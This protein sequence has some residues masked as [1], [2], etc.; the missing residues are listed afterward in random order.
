MYCTFSDNV[1][2]NIERDVRPAK[3]HQV[4]PLTK[5]VGRDGP[6]SQIPIH[7]R[8]HSIHPQIQRNPTLKPHFHGRRSRGAGPPPE[9]G[10]GATLM[11][12][13]PSD[14]VI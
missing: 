2:K 8:D 5:K 7:G 13:S 10:V 14:F 12:M 1:R 6:K 9:F 4:Y 3:M 11:Q